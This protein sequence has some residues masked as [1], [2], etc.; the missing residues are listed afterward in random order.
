MANF[1]KGYQLR[2]LL[3][4]VQVLKAGQVPPNSGSSATLFT[5]AGGMVLVTSLVGRVSTVLSGTT[6]AISLGATPTVGAAGA[7]VAGIASA[8]VVGGG[9]AGMAYAVVAT[10]AGAPTTLS[11]GGASGVAGKSPFLAQS[12]FV[13]QAGIVTVTTSVATMTGAIDWYLTYVPLDTGAS[14]S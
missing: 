1:V 13:V 8:T 10:I 5:V 11:N 2:E 3:Y 12:A 14:V 7:Q 9:E 4:G 6:G